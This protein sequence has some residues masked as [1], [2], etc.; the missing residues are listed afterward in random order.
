MNY[1]TETEMQI[2]I[3]AKMVEIRRRRIDQNCNRFEHEQ[4]HKGLRQAV[5]GAVCDMARALA[6][7]AA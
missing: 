7:V 3:S 6:K 2:Q 1:R 5:A 4:L